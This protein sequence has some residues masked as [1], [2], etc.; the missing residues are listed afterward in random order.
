MRSR[1]LLHYSHPIAAKNTHACKHVR[2]H[3]HTHTHTA[4]LQNRLPG[5]VTWVG[6]RPVQSHRHPHSEGSGL[7]QFSPVVILKSLIH[8]EQRGT[9]FSFCSEP[10]KLLLSIKMPGDSE[11]GLQPHSEVFLQYPEGPYVLV[12]GHSHAWEGGVGRRGSVG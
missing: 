12:A 8:F 10:C 5:R 7:V 2:A 6:V 1:C 4:A 11:N 3:T 9:P